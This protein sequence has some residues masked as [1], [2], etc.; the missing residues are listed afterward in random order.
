[1]LK[2]ERKT[3]KSIFNKNNLYDAH[4]MC[5]F[6]LHKSVSKPCNNINWSLCHTP[7]IETP[8]VSFICEKYSK[9][10]HLL[11]CKEFFSKCK[12]FKNNMGLK[13]TLGYILSI[14]KSKILCNFIFQANFLFFSENVIFLHLSRKNMCNVQGVLIIH[15]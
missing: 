10:R 4:L 1:M 15:K 12:K 14:Y 11:N 13:S 3:R 2:T 8:K 7:T 6:I 9:L 5:F